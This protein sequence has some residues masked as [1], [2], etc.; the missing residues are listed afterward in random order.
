MSVLVFFAVM[1]FSFQMR[2]A[3]EQRQRIALLG[4]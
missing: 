2:N 3:L 1:A 4:R